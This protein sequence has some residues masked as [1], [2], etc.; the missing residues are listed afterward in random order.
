MIKCGGAVEKYR[1]PC[2]NIRKKTVMRF[3]PCEKLRCNIA[4]R[5]PKNGGTGK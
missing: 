1:P 5:L 2:D 4:F 3:V